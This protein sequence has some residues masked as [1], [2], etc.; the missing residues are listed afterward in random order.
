MPTLGRIFLVPQPPLGADKRLTN[1]GQNQITRSLHRCLYGV[2]VHG[3][4]ASYDDGSVLYTEVGL[5]IL[6]LLGLT[7][8]RSRAL[9]VRQSE[10]GDPG[11]RD[12]LTKAMLKFLRDLADPT[13]PHHVGDTLQLNMLAMSNLHACRTMLQ[14]EVEHGDI[15]ICTFEETGRLMGVERIRYKTP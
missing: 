13:G 9:S 11:I 3:A 4:R 15:L 10:E 1:E 8:L 12:S 6:G 14:G 5:S 7:I 2:P